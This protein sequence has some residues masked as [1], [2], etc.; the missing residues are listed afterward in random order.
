MWRQRLFQGGSHAP[1]QRRVKAVGWEA[2]ELDSHL[3]LHT[4]S[5]Q[6]LSFMAHARGSGSQAQNE[7][8]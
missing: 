3:Q 4:W 1:V 2:G 8:P 7:V 6:Q 5:A